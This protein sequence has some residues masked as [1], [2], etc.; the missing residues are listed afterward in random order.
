MFIKIGHTIIQVCSIVFIN[1][2]FGSPSS[3]KPHLIRFH[4][5]E[6]DLHDSVDVGF[7]TEEE[8][9]KALEAVMRAFNR[10]EI[11]ARV[12]EVPV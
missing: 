4:L 12:V 3:G 8:R 2:G 7:E 1:T 6:R 5:N 11:D 10:P 9:D